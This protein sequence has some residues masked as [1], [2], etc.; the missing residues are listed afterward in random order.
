MKTTLTCG[1][2]VN[3]AVERLGPTQINFSTALKAVS[4]VIFTGLQSSAFCGVLHKEGFLF[5]LAVLY[6]IT[7]KNSL[8]ALLSL[9]VMLCQRL[10][11]AIYLCVILV[12]LC[13]AETELRKDRKQP[14]SDVGPSFMK[15]TPVFLRPY[16]ILVMRLQF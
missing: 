11:V 15:R 10:V 6:L 9:Q 13:R 16:R 4:F 12:L 8:E 2:D 1:N 5:S 14:M 3:V 7:L